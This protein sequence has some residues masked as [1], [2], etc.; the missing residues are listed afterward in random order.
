[1]LLVMSSLRRVTYSEL[2]FAYAVWFHA[3]WM[4]EAEGEGQNG[5]EHGVCVSEAEVV[6][7]KRGY[8]VVMPILVSIYL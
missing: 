8:I 1:M 2:E 7:E 5:F 4:R 3:V 6:A